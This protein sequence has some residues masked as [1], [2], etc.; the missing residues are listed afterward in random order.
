MG[1]LPTLPVRD[2]IFGWTGVP[3]DRL[4]QPGLFPKRVSTK[5]PLR[6]QGADI[7][8]VCEVAEG[9]TYYCKEDSR[10]RS[11]RL[12]D[13]VCTRLADHVG[14]ATALCA[15]VEDD[16]GQ[17]YFGSLQHKSTSLGFS[18]D[19]FLRKPRRGE[20]GQPSEWPGRHLSQLYVLDLFLDN[21]DRDMPN[22]VLESEGQNLR[23]CAIDFAASELGSLSTREFPIAQ[24]RT[25]L[26]GKLLRH[27]HGFFQDSALEMIDRIAAVPT[28]AIAGFLAET[29]SDWAT[30][31]Q[32]EDIC[33]V[34]QSV[35]M[36]ERLAALR[37][38][39]K[40]GSLL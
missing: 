38:G 28:S 27:T 29:P 8:F 9:G 40:D 18:A 2:G 24:T 14:V 36:Q 3:S 23:L 32:R 33:E 30:E 12:I 6:V 19:A 10:A 21:A 37:S 26:V 20:L 17:T 22:F 31:M 13:W 25:F 5:Y 15:V 1:K 35:Q 11:T 39:I 4:V 7:A 16:D 34:W